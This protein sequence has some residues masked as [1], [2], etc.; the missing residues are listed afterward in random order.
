MSIGKDAAVVSCYCASYIGRWFCRGRLA[1]CGCIYALILFEQRVDLCCAKNSAPTPRPP[2]L[3]PAPQHASGCAHDP[4]PPHLPPPRPPPARASLRTKLA[5]SP[6]LHQR[7][8]SRAAL[9]HSGNFSLRC[10]TSPHPCGRLRFAALVLPVRQNAT[11]V[12]TTWR[13]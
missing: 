12:W 1:E 2:T 13:S 5:P 6:H 11:S 9:A 10:S 3:S 4:R 7:H 8:R